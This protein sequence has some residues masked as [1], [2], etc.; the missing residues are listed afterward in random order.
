MEVFFPQALAGSRKP[1]I[2]ADAAYW[3]L[4]QDSRRCTGGFY[5]DEAVLR[6]A[7]VTD[8]DCYALHPGTPLALD[9]FLD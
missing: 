5:I 7:G 6:D 1:E 4:T 9:L 2:M 8:L 3:I